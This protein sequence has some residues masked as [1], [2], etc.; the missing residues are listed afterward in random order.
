MLHD[1]REYSDPMEFRPER[2]LGE[3]PELDPRAIIFG[4]GRR[5]VSMML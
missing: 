1:P 3:H 4:F 2:F 5:W